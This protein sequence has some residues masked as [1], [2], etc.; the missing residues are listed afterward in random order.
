MGCASLSASVC[1]SF[2]FFLFS[3]CL[4]HPVGETLSLG[5]AAAAQATARAGAPSTMA[6]RL[7]RSGACWHKRGGRPAHS[8]NVHSTAPS[9][10]A[11]RT[12]IA[13]SVLRPSGG[14]GGDIA[15][16]SPRHSKDALSCPSM[17][18]GS[19]WPSRL[20]TASAH[21]VSEGLA[22]R[23]HGL[24]HPLVCRPQ[25]RRVARGDLLR[26]LPTPTHPRE[27]WWSTPARRFVLWSPKPTGPRQ[28]GWASGLS[29]SSTAG[30]G[31]ETLSCVVCF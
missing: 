7:A 19:R 11:P 14:G 31:R 15:S 20:P 16:G 26:T 1:G 5:R 25:Q 13:M 24:P 28:P 27:R 10:S 17:D 6:R 9:A 12:S 3:C 29:P 21:P 8:Q 23:C 2:F 30:S 4:C 18:A 22:L